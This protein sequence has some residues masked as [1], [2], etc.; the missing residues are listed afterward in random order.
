M[1]QAQSR[2][3][4]VAEFE[5][6]VVA[7]HPEGGVVRL[8]DV[9]SVIDSEENTRSYGVTNGET[10]AFTSTDSATAPRTNRM[11]SEEDRATSKCTLLSST[12]LNPSAAA[13]IE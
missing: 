7:S 10:S 8:R 4:S 1:V 9:A 13:W 11:S 12:A 5:S 3:R 6:I 2:L